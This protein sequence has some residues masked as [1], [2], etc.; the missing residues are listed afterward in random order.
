MPLARV[1][2][3]QAQIDRLVDGGIVVIRLRDTSLEIRFDSLA[4]VP[5]KKTEFERVLDSLLKK[6]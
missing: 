6:R 3:R 5:A 1:T 4:T 2:L